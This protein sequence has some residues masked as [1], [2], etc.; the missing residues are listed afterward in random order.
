MSVLKLQEVVRALLSLDTNAATLLHAIARN[1][2]SSLYRIAG[3]LA[4]SATTSNEAWSEKIKTLLLRIC[5]LT[6]TI[7]SSIRTLIVEEHHTLPAVAML[8]TL[9]YTNDEARAIAQVV[10]SCP[11]R[12]CL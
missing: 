12:L 6:P 5:D 4:E 10:L 7:A 1:V 8:I 2:P 3:L 11:R 9:K